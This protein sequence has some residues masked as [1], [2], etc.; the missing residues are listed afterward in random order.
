VCRGLFDL[1]M[2]IAKVGRGEQGCAQGRGARE[3]TYNDGGKGNG[4]RA[5]ASIDNSN[6]HER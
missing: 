5:Q 2:V 4:V 6:M 3:V 1:A